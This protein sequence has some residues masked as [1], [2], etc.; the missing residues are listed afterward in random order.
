M[1]PIRRSIAVLFVLAAGCAGNQARESAPRGDRNT[2]TQQEMLDSHFQNAYDAVESLRGQWL[3]A[4][5][6]DSFY[7]P[8]QVWVYIDNV[9]LGAVE[10]L[11]SLAVNSIVSIRH[12]GANEAT[13]RWG[14]GHSAGVI[15]VQTLSSESAPAR[16]PE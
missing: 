8:S 14:V 16:S 11:R 5:G 1:R 2:L 10:T 7:T 13:A 3:Q 6:T 15:Q 9:K 4:R 12:L